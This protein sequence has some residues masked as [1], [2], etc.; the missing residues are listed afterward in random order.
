MTTRSFGSDN[1]AGVHPAVFDAL[2]RVN[3]GDA[4]AY[5]HDDYTASVAKRVSALF[6]PQAETFFVFNGTAANVISIRAVCRPHQGVICA[7]TAHINTDECGAPEWIAGVKLL[8]VATPDGKLT[9]ALVEQRLGGRGDEHRT[10]PRLVSISQTTEVGTCYTPTELKALSA[11][12][13]QHGLYLH[14]DGARLSNAAA[15]LNATLGEAAT[16]ADLISFGGTKNGLMAGESVVVTD[17]ALATEMLFLRKQ[18]MQLFSKMRFSAAQFDAFLADDLWLNNARHANAMAQLLSTEIV[19][20]PGFEL[21]WPTQA[22]GVFVKMPQA[23]AEPL[24]KEYFFYLWDETIPV[25]RLMCHFNTTESDIR[26]FLAAVE[27]LSGARR[28]R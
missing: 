1:H 3:D 24:Q 21:A 4:H 16:G 12:C 25:A 20:F 26:G 18:S 5:G 19:R 23:V 2:K 8:T 17:P 28:T 27:R 11:F 15:A 10:Q 9:P 6:G 22:N 14:I 13:H 7:Q